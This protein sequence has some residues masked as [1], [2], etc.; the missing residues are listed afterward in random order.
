M[1]TTRGFEESRLDQVETF[2][3]VIFS[4]PH[5][6]GEKPAAVTSFGGKK[7]T[8]TTRAGSDFAKNRAREKTLDGHIL[9]SA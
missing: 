1:H 6:V 2:S 5:S 9:L 3:D 8:Q 4:E 7:L